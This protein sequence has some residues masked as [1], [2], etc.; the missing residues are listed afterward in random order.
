MLP[1]PRPRPSNLGS[2]A[3]LVR[4]KPRALAEVMNGV[5]LQVLEDDAKP[6]NND[7]FELER[8]QSIFISSPPLLIT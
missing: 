1:E 8:M 4:S 2:F 7:T 5:Q 3:G 6:E